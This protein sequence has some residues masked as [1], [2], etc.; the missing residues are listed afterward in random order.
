[1]TAAQTWE[2][3]CAGA[4]REIVGNE[5]F[6][7][8]DPIAVLDAV[9]DWIDELRDWSE[10]DFARI[11]FHSIGSI[12]ARHLNLT[13]GQVGLLCKLLAAKQHDYGHDNIL[14]F[15]ING[16]AV[17]ISDKTARLRNLY[18]RDAE[19]KNEALLD[20]WN[21]LFGYSVIGLM[22]CDDTFKL[23]LEADVEKLPAFLEGKPVAFVVC[24]N[25]DRY[26]KSPIDGTWMYLGVTV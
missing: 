22:V 2:Q 6:V 8:A 25:G 26:A 5:G 10:A 21:D 16:I 4:A 3:A 19:A 1:M 15:G 20:S 11:G 23:P 9:D 14:R 24:E 18:R 7:T 17:R 12:V 13:N